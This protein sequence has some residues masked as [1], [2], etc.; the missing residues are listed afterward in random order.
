VLI[1]SYTKAADTDGVEQTEAEMAPTYQLVHRDA[2][3][4]SAVQ[5]WYRSFGMAP[6]G[7][8]LPTPTYTIDDI[9]YKVQ[10]GFSK[11]VG[12]DE[13]FT[14]QIGAVDDAGEPVSAHQITIGIPEAEVVA[15]A[16]DALSAHNGQ[17]SLF[18]P[19]DW[20]AILALATQRNVEQLPQ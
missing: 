2:E 6:D 5:A 16:I 17:L 4:L 13:I 8:P 12:F 14:I 3:I 7:M 15:T 9:T 18:T 10:I 11:P 20:I 1:T 19:D